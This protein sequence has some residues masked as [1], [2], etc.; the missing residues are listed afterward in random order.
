[1]RPPRGQLGVWVFGIG[2]AV[3]GYWSGRHSSPPPSPPSPNV[4]PQL[5]GLQ[6]IAVVAPFPYG[7]ADSAGEACRPLADGEKHE[8]ERSVE[9]A[10]AAV[11]AA[12]LEKNR[13][14]QALVLFASTDRARLIG[15]CREKFKT[16][17]ELAMARGQ[18][19]ARLLENAGIKVPASV[20][21][22]GPTELVSQSAP[23]DRSVGIYG[24]VGREAR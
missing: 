5:V 14:V 19:I 3:L 10:V 12:Q 20:I 22:G 16:N 8:F 1:M 18:T 13:S 9:K 21:P 23:E 15:A 24:L 11:K 2:I 17:R 6:Q 7:E 4:P